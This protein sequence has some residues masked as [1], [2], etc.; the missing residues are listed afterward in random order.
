MDD[1]FASPEIHDEEKTSSTQPNFEDDGASLSGSTRHSSGPDEAVFDHPSRA[2]SPRTSN[3]SDDDISVLESH[4]ELPQHKTS[5]FTPLKTRSPFRNPSSVRAMQMDTTPPHLASPSSQQRYKISTPSRQCTPRSTRSHRSAMSSPSKLSP[6]K[7]VKKEYPL[8]LLHVTLLPIPLVYS[9]EIMDS[10]L[11]P[12]ILE[13]WKLLQEKATDTVLERGILIP[14]PK[15]DYDLLEERLLESLELKMPRILKCGHFHLSPEEEADALATD[16]EDGDDE[17]L[18]DADICLDCGRRVRD[19]KYGS[20]GTGSKRWDIKLFAANGLMRAG[21]WSAAWREMERVDVEIL[22]WMDEDMKRELELR[23]EEEERVKMEAREEGVGGLDD[24]RLRE[25]YGGDPQ[26]YVDGLADIPSAKTPVTPQKT[27]QKQTVQRKE[28]VPLWDL[29]RDY[30]YH[31]A[32]DRRNVAIFLLSMLV[33]IL[34][35]GPFSSNRAGS[36][37]MQRSGEYFVPSMPQVSD[38]GM[39]AQSMA[40]A[41]TSAASVMVPSSSISLEPEQTPKSAQSDETEGG[42]NEEA[43]WT[44]AAEDILREMVE[45]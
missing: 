30:V 5:P 36:A 13:N 4:Y 43:S 9:Q 29:F 14:H 18:D 42:Q 15:E 22:P 26:A 16:S 31:A 21:A 44:E 23:R 39:G 32:Q 28:D 27:P 12:S 37:T 19:G 38:V 2:S 7:K 3:G 45:D 24:E 1:T 34:S 40:S 20:A 25:I 8:V 35:M 33:L 41:S 17:D 6:T 11:P 10:V